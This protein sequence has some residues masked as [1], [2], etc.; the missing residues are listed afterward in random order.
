M[1]EFKDVKSGGGRLVAALLFFVGLL[2]VAGYYLSGA[3]VNG[4]GPLAVPQ[5]DTL[6]YMQAARRIVARLFSY[7]DRY[8]P[9][10]LRF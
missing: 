7:N 10:I 9:M 2:Q 4:D 8:L 6:L 5:P 1:I 3:L